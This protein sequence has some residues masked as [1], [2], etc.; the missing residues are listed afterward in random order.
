MT[1]VK[2]KRGC[3]ERNG[4]KQKSKKKEKKVS[5]IKAEASVYY[6]PISDHNAH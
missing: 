5:L 4:I 3:T 6:S 2:N 1:S